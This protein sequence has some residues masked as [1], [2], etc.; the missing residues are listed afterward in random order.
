MSRGERPEASVPQR[1]AQADVEF[2]KTAYQAVLNR[3]PDP[4]GQHYYLSRLA[5]G[6]SRAEIF[7]QL[8][9]SREANALNVKLRGSKWFTRISRTVRRTVAGPVGRHGQD[10]A[11]M[12]LGLGAQA[13]ESP[14]TNNGSMQMTNELYEQLEKVRGISEGLVHAVQGLQ[15]VTDRHEQVLAT[16]H[17]SADHKNS[18]ESEVV[19]G[20][21]LAV[22]S[23][24]S[25]LKRHE[26]AF[27]LLRSELSGRLDIELSRIQSELGDLAE[28][29]LT[30]AK[31]QTNLE[32]IEARL[33]ARLAELQ[34]DLQALHTLTTNHREQDNA[35]DPTIAAFEKEQERITEIVRSCDANNRTMGLK[36]DALDQKSHWLSVDNDNIRKRIEFIRKEILFELR[37]AVSQS[38]LAGKTTIAGLAPDEFDLDRQQRQPFEFAAD[39]PRRVNLGCGHLTLPGFANL[40]A[41]D[42]PGVDIVADL[43]RLPF[44]P[45]SIDELRATHVIE[46]FTEHALL[47]E[48]LPHWASVLR[49]GGTLTVTAPDARAI[50]SDLVAGTI[51]WETAKIVL[52]GGQ[53]YEGDFHFA[54]LDPS[55]ACSMLEATGFAAAQVVAEARQ[56]GDCLE[57]EI[58]AT[59]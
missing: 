15:R 56:N 20:L 30:Q 25:V 48:V 36:M 45:G 47:T 43:R 13:V 21:G 32:R 58:V 50:M 29:Q 35:L 4:T 41:R 6:I 40:D 2:I 38:T 54:L 49:P 5:A 28:Q 19:T 24:E 59:R 1:F 46:H 53:E 22:R 11:P 42:L 7:D 57:F 34:E 55:T 39:T 12:S 33:D 26:K 14:D 31:T 51:D 37:R 16:L 52:M 17:T 27:V 3:E 10:A 8:C 18:V 23:F 9:R 44:A